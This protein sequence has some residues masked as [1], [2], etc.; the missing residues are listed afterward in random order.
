MNARPSESVSCCAGTDDLL[1]SQ[2]GLPRRSRPAGGPRVRRCPACGGSRGRWAVRLGPRLA[3]TPPCAIGACLGK[4]PVAVRGDAGRRRTS[5]ALA[6]KSRRAAAGR[7]RRPAL[8]VLVRAWAARSRWCPGPRGSVNGMVQLARGALDARDAAP[9]RCRRAGVGTTRSRAARSAASRSSSC[10]SGG[11]S[12]GSSSRAATRTA[13]ER[14]GDLEG[15]RVAWR[16]AGHG[17]AAAAGAADAQSGAASRVPSLGSRRSRT[18]RSRPPWRPAPPMPAWRF[19]RWPSRRDST[20]CR[21]SASRSSSRLIRR[22][23]PAVE[24]LLD[25]ARAV[26]CADSAC[27]DARLRPVDERRGEAGGVRRA[28]AALS[29]PPPGR[30]QPAART[31]RRRVDRQGADDPRHHDEHAGLGAARRAAARLRGRVGLLGQDGG[32]RVRR[33]ARAGREGRRRCPARALACGRGGV[34]GRRSRRQPQGRDAQ[35]LHRRRAARRSGEDQGRRLAPRRRSR[36]S[37]RPRRRSPL[38][39]TSPARTRRSS[40]SGRRRGSSRR[41]RGT[42]RRARGWARR[43]RSRARGRPTRSRTAVRTWRPTTSTSSCS[44]KAARTCST[45]TT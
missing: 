10:T 20:G 16:P 34:H 35:R 45:R 38:A 12:R 13:S 40:R 30:S 43:S 2:H 22:R 5:G 32:R 3:H 1:V 11:A 23:G 7:Q 36:A 25:D 31:T 15:R 4:S 39:P 26:G 28:A 19:G 17:L 6:C 42:S 24:P 37:R 44:P 41:A 9:A 18:W 29:W 14:V 27:C 8:D 21:W 33:G